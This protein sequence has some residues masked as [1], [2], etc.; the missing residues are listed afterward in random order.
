MTSE[1]SVVICAYTEKR[2]N[3]LVAAVASVQ[4]QT[5][6]PK[7]I[8]IVIDDNPNLLLRVQENLSGVL[9]I[10]N[11]R[12]K[13]A[14]GARNSGAAATQGTILAF[15]D[16]DAIAHAD[17]LENL[18]A[19]YTNPDVAGTGG[20][21]EP[22]WSEKC[23]SW[24]PNEFNWVIGCSYRG[25]P[26]EITPVR[27]VIGANMS[28]RKEIF[29]LIGGFRESFGNKKGTS[30]GQT[31]SKW[32]HHHA[33][34]EETEF[35]MRATQQLPGSKWL[36]TPL[37]VVQHCVPPR[38]ARWR[39]FLWR[40]YD[41]GLGKASLAKLHNTQ[42]ALSS[43]RTYTFKV[44]PT[45]VR[46]GLADTFLRF[47]VTGVLRAGAI[48]TGLAI[49][50]V[51]YLVGSIYARITDFRSADRGTSL[52]KFVRVAGLA[53]QA[54][55]VGAVGVVPCA[56]PTPTS[57][58]DSPKGP[59][60]QN[61]ATVIDQQMD[62][63]PVR[64]VEVELG[65]ALPILSA[66][67]EKTDRT[68]QRAHCL[69]RLHDHPLGVIELAFEKHELSPPDYVQQIWN[70]LHEQISEHLQQ[71]GLPPVTELGPAGII[72]TQ[73]PFCM[74]ERDTFLA[75]APFV[76]VIVSTHDRAEQLSR[77]MPALLAQHYPHYEIIIVDNAPSNSATAEL[78]QHTYGHVPHLHY[79]RE[80]A[81]GLSRG[82]NRG[83][84]AA[85][86]EILA[87]TDDD[88]VVDAYWLL[89]LT[90]AFNV[91]NDVTCVTGL[92]LP[93]EL[94]TQAQFWF[95][96]FGGFSKG[97]RR[98]IYDMADNRPSEPLYPYTAGRFGTG[99]N[100]AFRSAFLK[101]IGGFDPAMQ[102]GMDIA[103]FFQVVR[104]GYKLVYE[105][106]ALVHHIHRRRYAEL[107][108]QIYSYGVA[109]TAYLTKSILDTPQL[110]FEL[111]IKIPYGLFFVLSTKSSKN[112]KKSLQY[113]RNLTLAELKGLLYGPIAYIGR[114][115]K[116]TPSPGFVYDLTQENV[117]V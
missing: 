88:V 98:R 94:E 68:Y 27:N 115:R 111:M 5:L 100:M 83:I 47:D 19:C 109:V 75:N 87:F 56:D 18:T 3:D 60:G 91:G 48:V 63:I 51:G 59:K 58:T 54:Q 113:P 99:A 112:K 8:V 78:I 23:P 29:T 25:L 42:T 110:F 81:P 33:G 64:I 16:D 34:D 72:Y 2:W 80:D 49:T 108:K 116:L 17:W 103:V 70:T 28:V 102:A 31:G 10:E 14:S 76:S 50:T 67:D 15:L 55:G 40:C 13:G 97:F 30:T 45:G 66:F 86:G 61:D 32:L 101:T 44:L 107:Q 1:I 11:S 37:A 73:P 89:H 41:E 38:R 53:G 65:Q 62:T 43:E 39:F 106:A 9:A 6:R 12:A 77:C 79:I 52:P 35:C 74:Q 36:Y 57:P 69:V 95:E 105:P 84:T 114:R 85:R 92:V 82:L 96:E 26:T 7:D 117:S 24:F 93:Q 22:R 4:R 71:D 104:G 21:I 20:K 46:Q 90:K